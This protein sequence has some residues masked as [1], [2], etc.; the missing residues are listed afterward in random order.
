MINSVEFTEMKVYDVLILLDPNKASGTDDIS[1]R[2]LR[3]CTEALF[4]PFHH[5]FTIQ[6]LRYSLIPTGWKVH[7]IVPVFKAGKFCQELLPNFT[8]TNYLQS[9][10]TLS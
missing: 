7:K 1:S 6:S 8:V 9:A 2:I 3:S 4:R 10:R 5:L